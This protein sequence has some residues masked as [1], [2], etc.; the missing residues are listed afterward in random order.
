[1]ERYD[2]DM[3]SSTPRSSAEAEILV[4]GDPEQIPSGCTVEQ[5]LARLDLDGQRVAV[6]VDRDVVPRST[7]ADFALTPGAHVEILEAVGGG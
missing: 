4:N 5:L 7:W 3:S 1:M 2:D 6:A